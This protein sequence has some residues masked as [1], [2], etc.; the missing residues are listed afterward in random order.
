MRKEKKEN[1]LKLKK[2]ISEKSNRVDN[3][4]R[5]KPNNS[6]GKCL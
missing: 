2:W 4:K 5:G 3:N 6:N 1:I